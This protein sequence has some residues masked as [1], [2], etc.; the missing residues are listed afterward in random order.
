MFLIDPHRRI[1]SSANVPPQRI[2]WASESRT[3]GQKIVSER[4]PVE[5]QSWV[6]DLLGPLMTME[7]AKTVRL[8]FMEERGLA[9]EKSNSNFAIADFNLCEH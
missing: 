9:S 4:L 3:L 1:I 7:E 8:A 2:D 5:L 6:D